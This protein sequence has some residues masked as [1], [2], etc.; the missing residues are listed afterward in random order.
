MRTSTSLRWLVV[1]VSA[2]VLLSITGVACRDDD[3]ED[4]VPEPAA[5]VASPV[6]AEPEPAMAGKETVRNVWGEEVDKPRYGGT[7]PIASTVDWQTFDPWY[8]GYADIMMFHVL[9]RP[10]QMNWALSPDEYDWTRSGKL[11]LELM[12]GALAESWEQQDPTTIILNIR[13]GVNWQDKAPMNSR[14]LIASDY[15]FSLHRMM[16][17]GEFAEAGPAPEAGGLLELGIE[18]IEATDDFTVEI[19]TSEFNILALEASLNVLVQPP[20]VIRQFGDMKDWKNVVG[21]GPF[22]VDDYVGGSSVTFVRNPNYWAT[23]P[24]HPDLNLQLPYLDELKFIVMPDL[25]AQYAAMRTGKVAYLRNIQAAEMSSFQETNPEL[26]VLTSVP[27]ATGPGM[28]VDKPPFDDLNVRIAMQKAINLEEIAASYYKGF[29]DPTPVGVAMPSAKGMFVPYVEWPDETKYK[30]AHDPQEAERLLDEAGYPRGE[31]GVRFTTIMDASPAGGDDID[32]YQLA[33]T[34]W[35]AIGVNVELNVIGD[36]NVYWVRAEALEYDGL[37]QCDCRAATSN[38][39][40]YLRGLYHSTEGWVSP[41]FAGVVDP[42]YDALVDGAMAATERE[43]YKRFI[44]EADM[45]FVEQMW[46]LYLPPM[47]HRFVVHSPWLRG[48]RGELSGGEHVDW[49]YPIKYMWVDQELKDEM[50]Q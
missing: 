11:S 21:S 29:A 23:D 1:A 10:A 20:D 49:F 42:A 2:A 12:S 6:P 18:S 7:I 34:Y 17:M 24:R 44:R 14:E 38:P 36:D 32:L 35:D 5:T 46:G 9:D 48:Y 22:S 28:R 26:V 37:T 8:G 15:V 13:E 30:Y 40:A 47:V 39:L 45:H 33:K 31:D 3:E 25:A 27:K 16:G 19:K 50:G 43:E 4:A 41:N